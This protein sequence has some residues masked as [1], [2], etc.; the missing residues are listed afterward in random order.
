[1]PTPFRT[2]SIIEN[3]SGGTKFS[4]P[5]IGQDKA[6][7]IR[8]EAQVLIRLAAFVCGRAMETVTREDV[9]RYLTTPHETVGDVK[10]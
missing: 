4:Q 5:T 9:E 7:I 1:M 8:D 2:L 6:V 3:L 10:E